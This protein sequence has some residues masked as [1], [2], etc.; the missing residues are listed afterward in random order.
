MP[1]IE[2]KIQKLTYEL[3]QALGEDPTR[4]GL[5]KT[6]ERVAKS[7]QHLTKGNEQAPSDVLKE[8]IFKGNFRDQVVVQN[9]D[10]FSVCEHH[11]LPFFGRCDIAYI[12]DGKIV[13][14]S[15][16]ARVVEAVSRRL[17]VQER[18]TQQIADSFDKAIKPKGVAVIVRAA[19][20]CMAMRGVEKKQ[21]T[22]TTTAKRGIYEK[23]PN[24]WKELLISLS[25][26]KD[27]FGF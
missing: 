15:K 3:L 18:M 26:N 21:C 27:S 9:I 16:I 10:F 11:L 25:S 19:H 23:D 17:Q 14:L 2:K 5:E 20:S 7:W 24:L 4:S 12:P 8:A 6:P 13:G 22:V 1:A